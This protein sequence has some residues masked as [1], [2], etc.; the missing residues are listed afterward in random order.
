MKKTPSM[1]GVALWVQVDG[2]DGWDWTFLGGVSNLLYLV[3][4][5]NLLKK[6]HRNLRR[7]SLGD[8]N[9][10]EGQSCAD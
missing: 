1:M 10:S 4:K 7:V 2:L 6:T 8:G 5:S 3:G 9:P